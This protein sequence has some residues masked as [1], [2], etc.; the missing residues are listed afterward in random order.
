M[1]KLDTLVL[2]VLRETFKNHL[3]KVLNEDYPQT[4][5]GSPFSGSQQQVSVTTVPNIMSIPGQTFSPAGQTLRG[6]SKPSA[7]SIK[8]KEIFKN[9]PTIPIVKTLELLGLLNAPDLEEESQENSGQAT[10]T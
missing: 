4:Q 3:V 10:G 9:I 5:Y 1:N 8:P 7:P 2:K 6:N